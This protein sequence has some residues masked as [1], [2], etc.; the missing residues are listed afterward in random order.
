MFAFGVR[1]R[2]I[3]EDP[4]QP[5]LEGRPLLESVDTPQ[6]R[7]PGV[8]D[9]FFRNPATSRIDAGEPEQRSLVAPDELLE[10][11]LVAL[12]DG[13]DE[14][15]LIVLR[16]LSGQVHPSVSIASEDLYLFGNLEQDRTSR[17]TA[18]RVL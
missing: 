17:L 14:P 9:N 3:H 13:V 2:A 7:E 16:L 10:R 11:Q 1:T 12:F 6:H 8:L 15:R 4:K 18:H 5:G